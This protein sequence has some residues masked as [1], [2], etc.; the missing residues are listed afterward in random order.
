MSFPSS[1]LIMLAIILAR[2]LY[3]AL[4]RDM[5]LILLKEPE[6]AY[7]GIKAKHVEFVLP[8]T[9]PFCWKDLIILRR[10]TFII[11]QHAL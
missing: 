5:G 8:P 11:S 9:L 10:S 7:L 1:G 2:I 3:E 6:F 4:H